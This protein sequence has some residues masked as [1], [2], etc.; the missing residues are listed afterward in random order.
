MHLQN[1]SKEVLGQLLDL[2][3][4]LPPGDYAR[5]LPVLS[6]YSVGT[7][8][9]HV[10]EFYDLLLNPGP[11]PL[12]YDHRKHDR[13]LETCPD[14]AARKLETLVAALDAP[15]PDGPLVLETR[16]SPAHDAVRVP[17]SYHRELLYN[18]EHAIHHMALIRIAVSSLCP[19]LSLP[20]SFGVAYATRRVGKSAN[21]GMVH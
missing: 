19:A 17:T 6:G 14:R 1:A 18:L 12:S 4:Q 21:Q 8:V 7:H 2:C 15:L 3:R 16:L 11:G 9:R 13:P 20:E 5:P 10:L